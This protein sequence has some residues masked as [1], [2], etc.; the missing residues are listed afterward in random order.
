MASRTS[1]VSASKASVIP[2]LLREKI[3]SVTGSRPIRS[4]RKWPGVATFN[5]AEPE[6]PPCQT[7]IP[8]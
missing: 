4:S 3:V 6:S 1:G 7:I 8:V 5:G 2:R